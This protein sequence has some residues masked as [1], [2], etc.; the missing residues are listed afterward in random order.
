MQCCPAT[1][2][3]KYVGM[4]DSTALAAR[5]RVRELSAVADAS[6]AAAPG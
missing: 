3:V 2:T 6:A 1:A 5:P 4:E